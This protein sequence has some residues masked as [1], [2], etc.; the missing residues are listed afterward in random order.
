MVRSE[1]KKRVRIGKDSNIFR[2]LWI[3]VVQIPVILLFIVFPPHPS[4]TNLT[5]CVEQVSAPYME[6]AEK[7][8]AHEMRF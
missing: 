2:D 8:L 4:F 7:N 5:C 6:Y 3:A 1:K